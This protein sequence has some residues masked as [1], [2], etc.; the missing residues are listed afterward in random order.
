MLFLLILFSTQTIG[1]QIKICNCDKP[2]TKGILN[3]QDPA[4]C[5]AVPEKEN[6]ELVKYEMYIKDLNPWTAE[7]YSC[8]QWDKE[9]HIVGYFFGSYDTTYETKAR[10]VSKEDCLK[11]ITQPYICG[12]NRLTHDN[13]VYSYERNPD[14]ERE[15]DVHCKIPSFKLCFNEN[16]R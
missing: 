4:Y 1:Q 8:M 11:S 12:E 5:S 6:I 9:K 16:N 14:G 10:E 15:M 2:V 3:L 7:G 13:G